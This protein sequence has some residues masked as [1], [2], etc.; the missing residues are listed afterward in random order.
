[1]TSLRLLC[2]VGAMLVLPASVC[3]AIAAPRQMP[4]AAARQD[5]GAGGFGAASGCRGAALPA[6]E[7]WRNGSPA[8]GSGP[9]A[10]PSF[11][12]RGFGSVWDFGR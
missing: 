8:V 11:P 1:M 7:R 3:G 5:C 4:D 6:Y 9:S 10:N 12:M 2:A